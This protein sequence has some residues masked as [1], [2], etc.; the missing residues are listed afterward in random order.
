VSVRSALGLLAPSIVASAVLVTAAAAPPIS[1]AT[2]HLSFTARLAPDVVTPGTRMSLVFDITPRKGM[3]VYAPGAR[4][5]PV[6][7]ALQPSPSLTVSDTFYPPPTMYHFKP[8]NEDVLVY[9]R[10]F[11][12]TLD[13]AAGAT[14]AQQ[15]VLKTQSRLTIKGQLTYQACDD[16]VCYLPAAVPFEW[17]I[18]IAR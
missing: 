15:A 9:E 1:K 12:L 16:R 3:H 6:A 10:P 5:R 18:A 13:I 17:S 4:Y 11:R 7:I 8:L 2:R 14:P